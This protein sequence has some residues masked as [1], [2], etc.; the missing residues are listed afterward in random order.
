MFAFAAT[1]TIVA[2]LHVNAT[3]EALLGASSDAHSVLF[4]R[5]VG[6]PPCVTVGAA[7]KIGDDATGAMS[8]TLSDLATL[9]SSFA[10]SEEAMTLTGDGL[11]IIGRSTTGVFVSSSRSAIG[12]TDF[13]APTS[14][15]F[16]NVNAALPAGGMI[17]WPFLTRDGLS[18]SFS[19][20][21]ATNTAADGIYQTT[22]ASPA[23]PF[24]AAVLA[25]GDVAAFY[26]L[27]GIADDGMTAFMATGSYRTQ[28][29]TRTSTSQAFSTAAS[30]T[31]PGEAWRVIPLSGCGTVIGTC[32]PGGCQG[33]DVCVWAKQ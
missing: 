24:P 8:Y 14:A 7:L 30:S 4:L 15:G 20:S 1:G 17:T 33:E 26:G 16:A 2:S 6:A 3:Q 9:C 18:L 25:T 10:C 21:S 23:D 12:M 31:P 27:T 19:I 13:G 11:T 32:E 5:G 28:L 22:R 29:L